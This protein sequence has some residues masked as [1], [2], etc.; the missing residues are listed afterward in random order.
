MSA[1]FRGG[2]HDEAAVAQ[3]ADCP[4]EQLPGRNGDAETPRPHAQVNGFSGDLV[5]ALPA[6]VYTTDAQGRITSYNEA[7]AVLWG[8]R[9]ELGESKFCGSWKLYWP[10]GTPLPHDECPMALALKRKQP[11][12]GMEAIAERPDGTRV[13]FIPYPTPLFDDSGALIGAVNMLM[14]ISER[15]RAEESLARHKD[16]QTPLYRFTDRLYRAASIE[17]VYEAALD[18]IGEAL[19]CQRASILLFDDA[20]VMRFVAWRK[21]SHGY[22]QAVEGHSPWTRETK[23][24]HPICIEDINSADIKESLRA[25]VKA[26]GIGALAFI[27]LTGRSGLVGKFMTY[28][29]APHAFTDA[30]VELAV[31]IARQL[32]FSLERMRAEEA[33]S[34]AERASQFMASIIETS[35]DAIV[36]KDLNSIVTSWNRGAERLFGYGPSEIIGK[37]ITLLMPPDR[38]GEEPE[39]LSRIK[40]GERVAPYEAVRVRKDGSLVDVSVT[41]SPVTDADGNV[42][43]ASNISHDIT[44]RKV[45]QKRQ[46]LLTHEVHHRTKNLFA[47]VHSV[48]ARSF[49]DK[50]TVEEARSAVLNRLHALANAHVM[51]I[52]KDWRGADMAEIVHSEMS[53]YA[54]R[55]TIEGPSVV[56]AAKAAQN[57]ALALHELATNAAKYGALSN[58]TG[59]VHISWS[60][61]N[62]NRA[63][64]FRWQE[65]GGPPV[66]AP[67]RKGFGSAVLEQ[68]MAEQFDEPPQIEFAPKGIFYQ[69]NGSLDAIAPDE[70]SG[71]RFRTS[72]SPNS[73]TTLQ[74]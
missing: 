37:P 51:L 28:Y 70:V 58:T 69:L 1:S 34:R 63:F 36:S 9:P 30:E 16:Q 71:L 38:R 27:P 32:G 17:D 43:G 13:P 18:A 50:R 54:G 47:V 42:I 73:S 55:V 3:P 22:R 25:T 60:L 64:C 45:N 48:V 61:D 33:R 21:L 8:C 4:T 67:E 23:N 31:T 19:D 12:R 65:R 46:E 35:S 15:K 5:Q 10:D 14:D 72:P 68:V 74:H 53:P 56:L 66:L 24:P 52:E 2:G 26:E 40:R 6:A 39:I 59:R 29:S 41:V 20:G 49:A 57:F 7:A 44:E 11:I 62:A